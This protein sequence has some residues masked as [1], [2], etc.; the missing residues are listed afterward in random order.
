[1]IGAK[2]ERNLSIR[3]FV[4]ETTTLSGPFSAIFTPMNSDGDINF[5]MLGA[6]ADYQ[7]QNG[8]RGFFACGSTGEALLLS[9]SERLEVT[10]RLVTHVNGRATVIAHVGH[11]SSD[12]AAK[13][14]RSAADAGADWIASVAPVY[15][16]TTF[17]G[18]RR[19]F[20]RIAAATDLPFMIYSLQGV[21]E[22]DRDR[23]FFDI[24]RV[25]G[26]KYTGANFFSVQQ[27]VRQLDKQVVLMSGFDEQFV[28]SLSFGFHGCIGTTLNFAPRHYAEIYR[29]YH[30]GR[31][32]EAAR[33]Q[34]DINKLTY[35]MTQHENW[36][37]RK[38][39][40]RYIGFDCGACRAPF[41]PLSQGEYNQFASQLDEINVIKRNQGI[42]VTDGV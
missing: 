41:A 39:I 9:E 35:L 13:L 36:S 14:A 38:A 26:L 20:A 18:A 31:I 21:I 22:P 37:Y 25:R 24:P 30:E 16:G 32:S 40:M 7:I 6:I 19:H 28:A 3:R 17:E 1:M 34:A 8:V 12:V 4:T 2:K 33:I 23:A 29:L 10:R 5:E 15:H 42:T 27:L 11:P